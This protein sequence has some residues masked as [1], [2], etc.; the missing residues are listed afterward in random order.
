MIALIASLVLLGNPLSAVP[1]PPNALRQTPIPSQPK[2]RRELARTILRSGPKTTLAERRIL[3]QLGRDAV[4][5]MLESAL[6]AAITYDKLSPAEREANSELGEFVATLFELATPSLQPK[7]TSKLIALYEACERADLEALDLLYWLA[8]YGDAQV[9]GPLFVRLAPERWNRASDLATR[10]LRRS[11]H[12]DAVNLKLR[13]LND[14]TAFADERMAAYLGLGKAGGKRGLEAVLALRSKNRELP[15]LDERLKLSALEVTGKPSRILS[16]ATVGGERFALVKAPG[17]GAYDDLWIVRFK[18]GKWTD[19]KFTGH[20]A[21]PPHT[22]ERADGKE[23]EHAAMIAEFIGG[24]WQELIGRLTDR[25]NDG[26]NDLAELRLGT[27]PA[28]PDSDGDSVPDLSDANPLTGRKPKTAL[29]KAFAACMDALAF[30]ESV[31]PFD[32]VA[33]PF[34]V[35]YPK[36]SSPFELHGLGSYVIPNATKNSLSESFERG[37]VFLALDR[38]TVRR[39]SVKTG[40]SIVGGSLHASF[41]Y[42]KVERVGDH[43]VVTQMDLT[44]VS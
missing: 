40:L 43:W 14:P 21:S 17:I 5:P 24:K 38:P 1:S 25:D 4:E 34:V 13:W 33:Q 41:W 23:A 30:Y 31:K 27:N 16:T 12:P 37:V 9:G 19:P 32:S 6:N 18:N 7:D 3:G 8:T 22:R 44:G 11:S 29:E 20:A 2:A 35:E 39:Y 26:L 10:G 28:A 42:F 36:G 15:P